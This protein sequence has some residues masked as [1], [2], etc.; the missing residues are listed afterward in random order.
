MKVISLNY[1]SLNQVCENLF[2]K[3]KSSNFKP[4]LILGVK[5]GGEY[6]SKKIFSLIQSENYGEEQKKTLTSYHPRLEFCHPVR[7]SSQN[8]KR[9]LKNYLKFLPTFLLNILRVLEAKF[10]FKGKARKDFLDISLPDLSDYK[11]ILV[12]D[13]AVDSGSTLDFINSKIRMV[14]SQAQIRNAVITVTR[15]DSSFPPDFFIFSN[16]TLVRFPWSIDAK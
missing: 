6:I 15:N 5:S 8:K 1:D 13:D 10:L 3:I 7:V 16:K 4:D 14:N 2:Q 11:R 12:I 9:H